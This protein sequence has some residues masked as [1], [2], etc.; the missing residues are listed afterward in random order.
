MAD[1]LAFVGSIQQN[2]GMLAVVIWGVIELRSI[3]RDFNRHD[4]DEDGRPFVRVVGVE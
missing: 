2:G 3:R 1:F 4:H